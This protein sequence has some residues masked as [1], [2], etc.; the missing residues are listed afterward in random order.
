MDKW[1]WFVEAPL[2]A[3]LSFAER[4]SDPCGEGLTGPQEAETA[5]GSVDDG[6]RSE[7]ESRVGNVRGVGRVRWWAARPLRRD[8][9]TPP[10]GRSDDAGRRLRKSG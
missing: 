9:T 10:G 7:G 6:G 5:D 2:Q 4:A 3:D 1:L 8:W